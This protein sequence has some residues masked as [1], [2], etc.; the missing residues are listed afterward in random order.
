MEKDSCIAFYRKAYKVFVAPLSKKQYAFLIKLQHNENIPIALEEM[1]EETQT[2]LDTVKKE[3]QQWKADWT[4]KSFF[5]D[6][7]K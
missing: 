4:S 6:L 2:K 5:L 7:T 3:W 1:A